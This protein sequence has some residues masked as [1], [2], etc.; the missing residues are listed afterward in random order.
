[1]NPLVTLQFTMSPPPSANYCKAIFS[2][3]LM[4]ITLTKNQHYHLKPRKIHFE[5]GGNSQCNPSCERWEKTGLEGEK[6]CPRSHS[7]LESNLILPHSSLPFTDSIR[8]INM[9]P[10]P[11]TS[12]YSFHGKAPQRLMYCRLDPRCSSVQRWDLER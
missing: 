10:P 8:N 7:C 9:Q 3:P 12:C 6:I 5:N 2:H 1:M 4:P 11:F